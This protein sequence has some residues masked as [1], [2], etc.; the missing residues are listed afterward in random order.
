MF[1]SV[2]IDN[3]SSSTDY[4]FEY[5]IPEY[6]LAFIKK[7]SRVK[8]K[9]GSSD[10]IWMGYV[11]D[12]Y[13]E[14]KFDGDK[15]EIIEV[16]DLEPLINEEQL[17]LSTYLQN[18]TICPRS[19]ILNL[20]IPSSL[21][22]KSSKYLI[23]EDVNN[24]DANL[25]ILFGGKNTLKL[26]N[27][28][29]EHH[30]L[31]NKAIKNG[32]IKIM[33][34]ATDNVTNPQITKYYLSE[35]EYQSKSFLT[36]NSIERDFMFFLKEQDEP[37]SLNEILESYPISSY[38]VKKLVDMGFINKK[39]FPK[40]LKRRKNVSVS[41]TDI[42]ILPDKFIELLNTTN[43]DILW[44]PNSQIEEISALVHI[45]KEDQSKGLKTLIL[46][47]DILSSY[48]YQ[49]LLLRYTD[50]QV[51]CLNSDISSREN[52]EIFD[53]VRTNQYDIMITT[54]IG[55]LYPYQNI[56]SI[57]IMDQE[58]DNYRNDQSPRYD[59][60]E[61]FSY[62]KQS[63]NARLIYHSYAPTINCYS[64]VFTV[65][66]KID[67][68]T[69]DVQIVNLTE[70]LMK[71]NKSPISIALHENIKNTLNKKEKV[72]L[73]LN[74][75]GYSQGIVCRSCGKTLKCPKC[76]TTLQYQQEKEILSCPSCGSRYPFEK[77]CPSCG[78]SYIRHIGLGME[79]LKEVLEQEFVGIRVSLL[80]DSNYQDLEEELLK[81]NDD[82]T[83][84]II[85]S[86]IFSRSIVNNKITLV[87]IMALDIVAKAP[88]Y[89][90]SEKAYS[91]LQHAL[92]HLTE[93]DS[94]M[95]IQTYDPNISVLKYFLLDDYEQFFIEELKNRDNLKLDP[96][97]E[98][99]RI[100]IKAEYKEMYKTAN[101]IRRSLYNL[102][103]YNVQ[104]LGPAYSKTEKA[105]ALIVKHQSKRINEIY[106]DIYKQYQNSKV[107]II[108]DKYPKNL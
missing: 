24:L 59:L 66:P 74:N 84:V 49:S 72:L 82:K 3:P 50:K 54:P 81:L 52:Y 23:T 70:E 38:R 30:Y 33:Y 61:V 56:G 51:L 41:S 58:N 4:E 93:Q 32:Q 29:D 108:F 17:E 9:F 6:V 104:I 106:N 16:L 71:G 55:A 45:I 7:G 100:F 37:L 39:Q 88:N 97:Y 44:M 57:I 78:S 60:N 14:S 31:I 26:T 107:M 36:S 2:I 96:I 86:D 35:E 34:E 13:P 91:M 47:P 68:K 85:S 64:K 22:L 77:K 42:T 79:K 27:E 69:K 95:I 11:I 63:L 18:D 40:E 89:H 62:R 73:I 65:L 28:L 19:R 21:R 20:M 94:K 101:D 1:A 87:G 75:K 103:K 10:R 8:V 105:V 53:L 90:A 67:S 102:I 83:D 99:N 92:L 5:L 25:A 43:N 48:R 76:D 80:N 46:V 15:K 12:I 98:V